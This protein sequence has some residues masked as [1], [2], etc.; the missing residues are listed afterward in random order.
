MEVDGVVTGRKR[1][2]IPEATNRYQRSPA[3]NSRAAVT[4]H[5]ISQQ[6]VVAGHQGVQ[7]GL[8]HH[9]KGAEQVAGPG[10][11]PAAL[12]QAPRPGTLQQVALRASPKPKAHF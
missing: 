9:Q 12:P 10:G 8:C 7:L 2:E 11:T 5:R 3:T 4:E 6:S 1:C